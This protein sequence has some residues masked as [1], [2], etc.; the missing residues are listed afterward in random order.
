MSGRFIISLTIALTAVGLAPA[1]AGQSLLSSQ[2]SDFGKE[3]RERFSSFRNNLVDN[4][5]QMLNAQ[6]E[7]FQTH[8]ADM[9]KQKPKPRTQPRVASGDTATAAINLPAPI[10]HAIA[11]IPAKAQSAPGIPSPVTPDRLFTF[12]YHGMQFALPRINFELPQYVGATADFATLWDQMSRAKIAKELVPHLK[13]LALKHGLNDYL[14]FDVLSSMIDAQY[15]DIHSSS[16][17]ALKHHILVNM[18]LMAR[19]GV[20]PSGDG[21]VLLA[22][23]QHVYGRPFIMIDGFRYY[24]FTDQEIDLSD[25]LNSQISTCKLPSDANLGLPLNLRLTELRLPESPKEYEFT[26]GDITL[27]G[28]LNSNV[29]ETLYHYPRTDVAETAISSIDPELRKSIVAQL[30]P[31]FEGMKQ[32]EAVN[33]LLSFV[34]EAF[35]YATDE[36]FHGFEKPYFVEESLYYPKGDCEDR[37]VL[38][39]F[40][41]WNVLGIPNHIVGYPDHETVAVYLDNSKVRGTKYTFDGHDYYISDPTFKGA[42]TGRCMDQY[43]DLTPEIDFQMPQ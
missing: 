17:A 26:D 13:Y 10:T 3:A 29:Y 20:N 4:Y 22:F 36:E 27:K 32:K 41:L 25:E 28:T 35:P 16:R 18:G 23:A 31:R 19:L 21:F 37:A 40:L 34:Q 15:A 12:T 6:W 14:T 39:S 5:Q 11:S 24:G 8:Q 30:K 42:R 38:Y 7:T 1:A 9:G 2:S 43:I 33:R